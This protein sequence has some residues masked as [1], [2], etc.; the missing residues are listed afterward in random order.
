VTRH[1]GAIKYLENRGITGEVIPH[2]EAENIKKGDQLYGVLPIPFIL[3]AI[4]R[5]A[6][7]YI[8]VIPWI[9]FTERGKELSPGEMEEAGA[10]ILK[11]ENLNVKEI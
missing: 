10:K 7:V 11:I 5:G 9:L 6:E 3:K 4:E 2:L 8:L 1:E